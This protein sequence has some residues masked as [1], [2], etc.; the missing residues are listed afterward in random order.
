MSE[1]EG[2]ATHSASPPLCAASTSTSD[3]V[4][5]CCLNRKYKPHKY[6]YEYLYEYGFSDPARHQRAARRFRL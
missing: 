1:Q 4:K 5:S 3:D 2:A 6:E